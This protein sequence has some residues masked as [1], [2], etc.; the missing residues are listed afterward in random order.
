MELEIPLNGNTLIGRY[1]GN[2][3]GI[4]S[5]T[6]NIVIGNYIS[7]ENELFGIKIPL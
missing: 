2:N 6:D 7:Y 3:V 4:S 5:A 1:I